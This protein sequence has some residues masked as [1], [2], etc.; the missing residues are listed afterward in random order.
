M[1]D[2][3]GSFRVVTRKMVRPRSMKESRSIGIEACLVIFRSKIPPEVLPLAADRKYSAPNQATSA[4]D[5]RG[6]GQT[7]F[8]KKI[9]TKKMS[10]A[11]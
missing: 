8:G 7:I 5:R 10:A 3:S 9:K 1:W 2:Y 6:H 4:G 11:S